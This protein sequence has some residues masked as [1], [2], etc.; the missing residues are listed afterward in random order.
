MAWRPNAR[1]IY[2]TLLLAFPA[3]FREEYGAE[4]DRI[5]GER[6]SDEPEAVLWLALLGDVLRNAPREH[7]HILGRDLRHSIRVFAKAPGFTATALLAL[8]LGIGAAV[9]IFSLIDTVMIR[10]LPFNEAERLVY[11]WTPLPRYPSLPRELGPSFADVLAWR[12]TSK[13]FVSITALNQRTMTVD[14]GGDPILVPGAMVLGNFFETLQAAP[15]LGRAIDANDDYPG[16]DQVAVISYA[17]WSSRFNRDPDVLGKG[18]RLGGRSY[19]IIGVMPPEFVYPHANDFPLTSASLKR[20][21]LW[22]PAGLTA[23]QETNRLMTCDAAIGRLRTDVT[24]PQAQTEMSAI[25]SGLDPLNLPEM[26]GMQSLLVPL[27]ETAVGPVRGLMRLL[28][29]A[30]IL[31]LLIACG[32]VASLLIARAATRDHEIGVRRALGAPRS[33]L[34]RQV[35]TESMVLSLTGGALGALLCLVAVRVLARMNPGDIPRFDEIS[36]DWRVLLFALFISVISGIVFGAF[37]ALASARVNIL[38][39]LREGG[40]RG[41]AAGSSRVRYGLVVVDVA[42]AVVLLGGAVLFIRSYL[43][44]Q[45]EEKGFAPSTLTMSLAADPQSGVT[46]AGIVAMSRTAM[47]RIAALPGVVSVGLTNTLPLSHHESTSTFRVEGYD[48]RPNQTAGWRQVAGDFFGAMQIPLIAGRYLTPDDVPDQPTPVPRAVVVNETFSRVY[49]HGRSAL[50]GHVQRGA[51]G[52]LWS[53]IVGVVADVR[54]ANLETPPMPTLYQPSWS[55]VSSLAIRTT[56]PPEVMV[57]EVGHAVRESRLPFLLADI[58]T[59]RERTTE[60]EARRRFQTVLLAAFAGIAVF[61]ALVGLYGL[62]SY[63]VRQRMAEIGI[64]IALGAQRS[65]VVGM[66]LREGLILT[67]AGL[68]IGLP[69]AGAMARWGASLLYGIQVLDPVTFIAVPVLMMAAASLACV[70]PAWK[71]SRV[72]PVI[73]LRHQ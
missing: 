29:G 17:F 35:L 21:D 42:L 11:M 10:S 12:S 40:G 32:N 67:A 8:A 69:V 38:D 54:H 43:Y 55:D 36:V 63:A 26:R 56:L 46:S 13:S 3:E 30:V 48:N 51:P 68:L 22:I 9:T 62:L 59:M 45:G 25:E 71:A 64:R 28:A 47:E 34:V 2:R 53:T 15:L 73:S 1:S 65:Q 52:V 72:D 49:F 6:M 24:L 44:V 18:L 57:S 31:V 39:L 5:V 16:K 23:L 50:G 14:I 4:M 19:R 58:Q 66:V 61:L 20:T 37:P 60:A 7:L 70:L 41:I 33:R 27:I